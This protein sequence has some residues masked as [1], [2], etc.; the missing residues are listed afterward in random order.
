MEAATMGCRFEPS[1]D[2]QHKGSL[3]YPDSILAGMEHIREME[4]GR[5]HFRSNEVTTDPNGELRFRNIPDQKRVESLTL[6]LNPRKETIWS[7]LGAPM[8]DTDQQEATS[9]G[10]QDNQSLDTKAQVTHLVPKTIAQLEPDTEIEKDKGEDKSELMS[11][12][13]LQD[14]PRSDLRV[15]QRPSEEHFCNLDAVKEGLTEPGPTEYTATIK[16]DIEIKPSHPNQ[17][18]SQGHQRD[19]HLCTSKGENVP[20]QD[21][22]WERN[23][24]AEACHD[25][26]DLLGIAPGHYHLQSSHTAETLCAL[27]Q[28]DLHS[29]F[30]KSAPALETKI[31]GYS[32]GRDRVTK[33]EARFATRLQALEAKKKEVNAAASSP[34]TTLRSTHSPKQGKSKAEDEIDKDEMTEDPVDERTAVPLKDSSLFY[35]NGNPKPTPTGRLLIRELTSVKAKR[36]GGRRKGR[37][38]NRSRR[39]PAEDPG[40]PSPDIAD[41]DKTE[42]EPA[43]IPKVDRDKMIFF[44]FIKYVALR[45]MNKGT[46]YG[47]THNTHQYAGEERPEPPTQHDGTE[48]RDHVAEPGSEIGTAYFEPG[49]PLLLQNPLN[50]DTYDPDQALSRPIGSMKYGDT[51]LA[52]IQGPSGWGTFFY[53]ARVTCVIFFEIPQDDDPVLNKIIQENTLLSGLGVTLTKHHHIRKHDQ[54]SQDS[55]AKWHLTHQP[56]NPVWREA[57]DLG[58]DT[59]SSRR[60]HISSVKRV[61]NLVLDPPGNVVILTP[62]LDLYISASLGY[63]MRHGKAAVGSSE[64]DSSTP[65]YTLKESTDFA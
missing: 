5:K 4:T 56:K 19:I 36:S 51:V 27:M 31:P 25:T 34:G 24:Y 41:R 43:H 22:K 3:T 61:F 40:E 16:K 44:S 60:S 38:R 12:T 1:T 37:R 2:P 17:D 64:T 6:D 49:T 15:G 11:P 30:Y 55:R 52:E 42:N 47:L 33:N 53:L 23:P 9:R 46:H 59:S 65:V 8:H 54:V 62:N 48:S 13:G 39:R 26:S 45:K 21:A 50:Q 20:W 7:T 57:A 35:S 63:H 28:T 29:Q 58:R 32:L 10:S 18:S 14:T